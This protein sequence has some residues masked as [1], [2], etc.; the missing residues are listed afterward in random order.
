MAGPKRQV[1]QMV[2][3][4]ILNLNIM[5]YLMPADCTCMCEVTP[6]LMMIHKHYAFY[7]LQMEI[8]VYTA[9]MKVVRIKIKI[10]GILID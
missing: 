10:E 2:K 8:Q 9:R 7:T 3:V 5:P 4:I 1:S 6:L